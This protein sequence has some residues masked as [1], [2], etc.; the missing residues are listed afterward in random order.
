MKN[1]LTSVKKKKL[2][3]KQRR[4]SRVSTLV[5]PSRSVGI[6]SI[7]LWLSL[8]NAIEVTLLA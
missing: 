7:Q 4:S 2:Q 8:G 1:I 5:I 6:A 3:R